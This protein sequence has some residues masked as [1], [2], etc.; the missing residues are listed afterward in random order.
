[1]LRYFSRIS[2]ELVS[3]KDVEFCQRTFLHIMRWLCGFCLWVCLNGGLCL[4]FYVCLAIP[5]SLEES[6]IDYCEESF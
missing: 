1:M 6:L 2:L 3:L 4:S 5:A